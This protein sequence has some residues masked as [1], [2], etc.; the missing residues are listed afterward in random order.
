MGAV[1]SSYDVVVIG[2][3]QAGLAMGRELAARGFRFTI[4]EAG[5]GPGSAWLDR[6]DSL[7]LF[8]PAEHDGLPG[9]AFPGP[10][11][12]CPTARE[13]AA[14]LHDYARKFALPVAH[15]SPVKRLV[16][17]PRG[18]DILLPEATLQATSVVVATG[19]NQR[20]AVPPGAVGL[21]QETTQLHSS[22]YRNPGAFP[23]RHTLVVGYGTSGAQIA[24]ELAA[25]RRVSIAGRPTIHVPDFV[26]RHA[27]GAYWNMVHRVLTLDTPIGRRAA[28]GFLDRGAPLIGTAPADLRDAGITAV[29]RFAGTRGGL[30][31]LADGSTL[32]V[33]SILWATGYRPD[34][35]WIDGL[36]TDARG[37]PAA[38][39]GVSAEDP[40]LYFL[41]I[42]FQYSLT[43]GLLGG[44]GRDAEHIAR[45]L[46]PAVARTRP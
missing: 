15:H 38:P 14:Y 37:W 21:R 30:P 36:V 9:A 24:L 33:D 43:S 44:V 6:W 27:G 13:V 40:G 4:L 5:A 3:G 18:F 35:S 39:R 22:G 2:A 11:G 42:P 16:R 7:R 8:T 34:Y 46:V 12:S 28:S 17:T 19:T 31:L 32:D 26:F 10:R 41:G 45:N 1:D 25:E 29:P 20:P 23:G